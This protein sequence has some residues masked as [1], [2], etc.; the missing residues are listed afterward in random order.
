MPGELVNIDVEVP[1]PTGPFGATG[2]GEN[3]TL[4]TAPAILNGIAAAVGV[5]INDLPASS[6]RLWWAMRGKETPP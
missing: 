6:E 1:D 3:P 2:L 5:R 4:P